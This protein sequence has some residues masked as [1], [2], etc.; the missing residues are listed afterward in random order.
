M[1]KKLP[2]LTAYQ[3]RLTDLEVC[4]T[5]C[6]YLKDGPVG[7]CSLHT[8]GPLKKVYDEYGCPDFDRAALET[9]YLRAGGEA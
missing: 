8:R 1:G 3:K 9:V 5:C 2:Q 7:F 6:F 4:F